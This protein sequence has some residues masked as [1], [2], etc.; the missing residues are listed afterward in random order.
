MNG[1][2]VEVVLFTIKSKAIQARSEPLIFFLGGGIADNEFI[3][4]MNL[5]YTL[6][7]FTQHYTINNIRPM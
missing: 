3:A 5:A 1:W 7:K 4:K 6:S 2:N